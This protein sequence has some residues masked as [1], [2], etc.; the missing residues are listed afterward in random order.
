MPYNKSQNLK[1]KL[2]L[3][4]ILLNEKWYSWELPS[5]LVA[6][7]LSNGRDEND[8]VADLI[9]NMK[10]MLAFTTAQSLNFSVPTV[11]GKH[12]P[13]LC[14][15]VANDLLARMDA[16]DLCVPQSHSKK[17]TQRNYTWSSILNAINIIIVH[18][19]LWRFTPQ[20]NS[21]LHQPRW[22]Q[23]CPSSPGQSPGLQEESGERVAS[24]QNAR[25][26]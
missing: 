9:G 25:I 24:T 8:W 10:E 5:A 23:C 4:K 13:A 15:A 21:P 12:Q 19:S 18:E 6:L 3:L 11:L 20:D 2:C 26:Q 16:T 17:H 1:R 7:Q 14:I 22:L